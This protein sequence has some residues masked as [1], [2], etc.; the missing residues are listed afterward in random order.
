VAF[1]E[2]N[3]G[4]DAWDAVCHAELPLPARIPIPEF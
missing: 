1:T 4:V 3:V 2:E